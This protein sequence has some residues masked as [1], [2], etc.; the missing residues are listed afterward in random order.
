M[1]NSKPLFIFEMANNHS[2]SV[3]HAKKII[4]EISKCC[5]YEEFE[6]AF[7]F[8]YRDLDTFIHKDYKDRM[9][10]KNIK[11]FTQTRLSEE[12]FIEIKQYC[13]N[14]GFVTLCTPFDEA[15]VDKIVKHGY[16]YLKIASCSCTDW[17][18]LEKI[19]NTDLPIILSTAGATEKEIKNVV[20]Y[21]KHRNKNLTLMH[22]VAEYPTAISN[23]QL[24]QLDYLKNLD[25]Y[26]KKFD[27][28]RIGYSTH[29]SPDNYS[30]VGIAI[31]KGATVFEKHVGV[32]TDEI[33]LN[34]Y[35]ANPEQIKEWLKNA[36]DAF[37]MCGLINERLG[38]T[39]KEESDLRALQRGAFAKENIKKGD[40]ITYD[41]V[42]YAIPGT[43]GQILAN[44]MSKYSEIIAEKDILM[45]SPV[46]F[47][48]T[49]YTDKRECV[50]EIYS[51]VSA[52]LNKAGIALADDVSFELSHHYGLARFHEIGTTII[53]CI[54]RE[55]CKKIIVELPN[56]KNP[57]HYHVK[58]E[59]TF[60][61]L[62]GDIEIELD[63]VLKECHAGEIITVERGVKHSFSSKNGGIFEEVSSTHYVDDSFYDD[64][65]IMNN[66]FRK[67]KVKY[68]KGKKIND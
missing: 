54:N 8:Q 17:P 30:S 21:F 45:D 66:K 57:T 68:Y 58:K 52:L 56:Q 19:S 10:I 12:Q 36:H 49:S 43:E 62:Y 13:E 48:E 27:D 18:L 35:S 63:G 67:T 38:R 25:Y 23:L 65:A 39:A 4:D 24:N 32:A 5:I 15:S 9:D 22:C 41:K 37:L 11:R 16:K 42:Y 50:E 26:G 3:D 7:K 40:L 64:E 2:G 33:S 44:D 6:Y 28:I 53:E 29:E 51:E 20:C 31:G 60:Q 47:E 14:K 46:M 55:Y 1:A 59:E 61:V 34:A